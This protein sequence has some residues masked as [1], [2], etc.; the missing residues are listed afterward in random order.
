M[1]GNDANKLRAGS[2]KPACRSGGLNEAQ[3]FALR[4]KEAQGFSLV[5][6]EN[7]C[8]VIRNGNDWQLIRLD[9]QAVRAVGAKR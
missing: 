5:R 6:E 4:Q 2:G 3:R 7:G 9:G 1:R 8:A